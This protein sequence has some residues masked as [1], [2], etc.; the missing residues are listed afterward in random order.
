MEV[1]TL[2]KSDA[3]QAWELDSDAFHVPRERKQSFLRWF[4]PGRAMGIFADR[5]LVAMTG[6]HGFGQ[7]FGGRSVPMGGLA[8]VAV[9]PDQ[10][11]KGHA[12]R[13]I[14]AVLDAMRERGEVISSLFPAM[15]RLYR[16]LGW[17]VAGNFLYRTVSPRALQ[18]LAA[19]EK[20]RVRPG[21][22]EDMDALRA[23]YASF[24]RGVNGFVDRPESWWRRA[25]EDLNER[26][27][28][29]AEDDRGDVDGYLVYR[30]V[31]GQYSS[32]GGPFRIRVDDLVARSRDAALV[33]WR[34]LGSWASQ[35][36]QIYYRGPAE[37]PLLLLLPEQEV[38][39]AAEIRWMTRMVDAPGALAARG[40]P[41]GVEVEV[42]LALRDPILAANDG[43]FVLS[44][45]KG[46]GRL[47]PGGSGTLGLDVG[48]FSAIYT[49]WAPAELLARSGRLEGGSPEQR[50]ALDAAFSGPTPWM[51]D[52]F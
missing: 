4:E 51:L 15:T 11:G 27:V 37:D 39:V 26:S 40:F 6:A 14:R 12:Q 19:P 30:Q 3:E 18:T 25:G 32:F 8:S 13:V 41:S 47:E 5:R 38:Q 36:E 17:E 7:F 16:G 24:A 45:S 29:V 50:A 33:L 31:D 35:V 10:R 52:E 2:R 22:A 9:A 20:G 49:G 42:D 43:R 28:F 44:V 1:R 48:A 23:C 21:G 46:R 34:L